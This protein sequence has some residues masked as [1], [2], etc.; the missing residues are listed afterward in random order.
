VSPDTFLGIISG[1]ISNLPKGNK[2][3]PFVF[4]LPNG[5]FTDVS[6]QIE[7][8]EGLIAFAN[9]FH[10]IYMPFGGINTIHPTATQIQ[11]NACFRTSVPD[12]LLVYSTRKIKKN[13]EILIDCSNKS[14]QQYMKLYIDALHVTIDGFSK[15]KFLNPIVD[16]LKTED[17]KEAMELI[18]KSQQL[19]KLGQQRAVLFNSFGNKFY[20]YNVYRHIPLGMQGGVTDSFPKE[21]KWLHDNSVNTMLQI[22]CLL[23][24][25]LCQQ[26]P[27]RKRLFILM[28]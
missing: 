16:S 27:P 19:I 21:S 15:F 26:M 14:S 17:V 28:Y 22:Y 3:P 6:K 20:A 10:S 5:L 13:E 7:K 11:A 9:L 4:K 23:D 24:Q 12:R 25:Q 8:G 1:R 18:V 2:L